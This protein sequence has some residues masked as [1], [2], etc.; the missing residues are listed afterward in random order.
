MLVVVKLVCCDDWCCEKLV[1]LV[2]VFCV[3]VC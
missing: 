1:E 3:G 2:G